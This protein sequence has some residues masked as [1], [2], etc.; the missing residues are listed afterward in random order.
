MAQTQP[1]PPKCTETS[2][3]EAG[4]QDQHRVEIEFRVEGAL[5]VLGLAETMLLAVEQK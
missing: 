1:F 2:E 5:N 4:T 3:P